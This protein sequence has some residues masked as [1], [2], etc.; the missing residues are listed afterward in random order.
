MV[1]QAV[2]GPFMERVDH[3]SFLQPSQTLL[4]LVFVTEGRIELSSVAE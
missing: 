2:W 1:F 3:S 4:K